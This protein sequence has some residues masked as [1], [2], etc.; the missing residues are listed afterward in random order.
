VDGVGIEALNRRALERQLLEMADALDLEDG[1]L[2]NSPYKQF[3]DAASERTNVKS[4][5]ETR[6]RAFLEVL[7]NSR[8]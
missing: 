6:V 5:R 1:E 8:A 4:Q 7:R 2:L 3:V